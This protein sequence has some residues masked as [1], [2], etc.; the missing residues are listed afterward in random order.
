[1]TK[2]LPGK[3]GPK[4]QFG[5]K[6]KMLFLDNL[7]VNGNKSRA[8]RF[9][10]I[11]QT[12]MKRHLKEDEEFAQAVEDCLEAVA[13]DLESELIRRAV[14]GDEED[15]WYNGDVVGKRV[16]KSDMLLKVAVQAHKK[17]KYSK[18]TTITH[19]GTVEHKHL[20]LKNSI[21]DKLD[22]LSGARELAVEAELIKEEQEALLIEDY[23]EVLGESID[24]TIIPDTPHE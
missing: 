8:C 4:V 3:P 2:K 17:N 22:K 9:V 19:Q 6:E 23:T 10:G 24:G 20:G 16:V 15:V 18:D 13:D 1:M 14:Q 7:H 11:S 5:T 21:L 12:T